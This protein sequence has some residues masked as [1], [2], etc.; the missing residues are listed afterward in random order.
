MNMVLRT[1]LWGE[2][3]ADEKKLKARSKIERALGMIEGVS[4]AMEDEK[5]EVLTDAVEMIDCALKV[6]F[7]DG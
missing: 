2:K 6:V 3:M 5:Q 1:R 4:I 7:E